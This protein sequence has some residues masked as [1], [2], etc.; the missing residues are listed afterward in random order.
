MSRVRFLRSPLNNLP[1]EFLQGT[2]YI[3]EVRAVGGLIR[4]GDPLF[5]YE[6]VIYL[7]L[8]EYPVREFAEVSAGEA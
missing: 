2:T 1:K 4:S 8:T 3:F 6:G 5:L 7:R